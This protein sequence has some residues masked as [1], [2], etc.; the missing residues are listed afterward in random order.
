MRDKNRETPEKIVLVLQGGGALGAFQAGAYEALCDAGQEPEWLAGI[1]IGSINAALIAGNPPGERLP[2]LRQFWDRV[3]GAPWLMAPCL[4]KGPLHEQMRAACNEGSAAMTALLGAPGFFRPRLPDLFS[5]LPGLMRQTS[6]YDT[7]PLRDTLLEL[8]DFDHL[9]HYGPRLSIGAVDVETGNFT[10]FDSRETTI[11]VDH[12]MASGALPP[13]FPAVEIEGRHYWDGG[14]VSNSPLQFVLETPSTRPL[15]IYQVDLYPSRDSLPRSMAEV[16]QRERE[17]RFSSRTRLNT[18]EFRN[19]HALASAAR[20]LRARLPRE[21]RDDPDLT[22][23]IEA[24]P[25]HPV[26]LMHLI[27]RHAS[28]EGASKDYEFSRLSML[29]HW[30]D[31]RRDAERSLRDPRWIN[32]QVPQDGL[33]IF[34]ISD[35]HH[36]E[37]A[38]S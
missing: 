31:G 25:A 37:A 36:Q 8:I 4:G 10:C 13:G 33:M 15:S 9:N 26:S 16:E 35:P 38:A 19:R 28:Y 1:S 27:Y 23:L 30:H 11:T 29:D 12:I 17:I 14:L 7:G 2:A 5:F 24:G 32:R 21:F 18:D 6:W 20:R 34:D 3:T 22:R